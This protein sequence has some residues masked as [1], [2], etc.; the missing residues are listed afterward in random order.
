MEYLME[1]IDTTL[2]SFDFAYCIVVNI[3]TYLIIKSINDIKKRPLSIW[4]K[5]V[6]LLLVISSTGG[7]YY[8]VDNNI[9]LILNSAILAPVF[10]SWIMKPICAKFGI[11]YKHILD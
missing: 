7:V 4:R 9:K 6:I 8:I 2:H 3:L 5:R 1:I 11:D 10:W